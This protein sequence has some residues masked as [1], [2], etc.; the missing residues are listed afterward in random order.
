MEQQ[1]YTEASRRRAEVRQREMLQAKASDTYGNGRRGTP[2]DAEASD[3]FDPSGLYIGA[4]AGRL[5]FFNGDGHLLTYARTG[6]G[7][8][9]DLILPNLAHIRGRSLVVVDV[10][11]GEN[12]FAS[13]EHREGEVGDAC[14][15]LNPF[16]LQ[17]LP[18]TRIN[19]LQVLVDVV[20]RGEH[21]DTQADE[22]AQVLIPPDPKDRSGGWVRRGAL[23]LLATRMEYLAHFDP[24]QCTLSGLWRFVNAFGLS[25]SLGLMMECGIESIERKAGALLMTLQEAPKQFEA[26]KAEV[27]EALAAFEPGKTLAASTDMHELD[28]GNLK[29]RPHTVYLIA[30]SS[31]L[32]AIA[33]WISLVVNYAVEAIAASRGAIR[34]TFLLDEFPQLPPAPAVMKALRLYRGKGIQLWFFAQGR[35]SLEGRWSRE[36]VK[37]FEDQASIL[38]FI[39]VEEPELLRDIEKWSGNKTVLLRGV[40]HSGGVVESA[41]ANLGEGRRAVLQS[42]DIRAIGAGRQI[43]KVAGCPYL[44]DCDR[45]PFYAVLPWAKQIKDVRSLHST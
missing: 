43:I 20:Q 12:A 44:F 14:V 24:D 2:P 9:R 39:A 3:L 29:Q 37:E 34:T 27:I 26:Y 19:P 28:F 31:K 15:Y 6:A 4:L 40:N 41:G 42:E 5:L 17:G 30:P 33:P 21:I 13:R 11:D 22:I 16:G 36:A 23:R 25:S 35:F 38:S 7:K 45:P 32:E 18:N 10:K 8:G 1:A